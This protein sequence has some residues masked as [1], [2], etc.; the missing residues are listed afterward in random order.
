MLLF[1]V[2][3][4]PAGT[5]GWRRLLPEDAQLALADGT[6]AWLERARRGEL[7]ALVV[8]SGV[9]EPLSVAQRALAEDAD[10]AVVLISEPRGHE[11]LVRKLRF[12]PGLLGDVR[13]LPGDDPSEVA[14]V[15]ADAVTGTRKRRRYRQTLDAVNAQVKLGPR[16]PE[17]ALVTHLGR[18]LDVAPV[19]VCA[20]DEQGRILAW[21]HRAERIFERD[22]AQVMGQPF[23]A[24][25]PPEG[26]AEWEQLLAGAGTLRAPVRMELSRTE[27]PREVQHVELTSTPLQTEAGRTGLMVVMEDVTARVEAERDRAELLRQSQLALAV[28]DEFLQVASHELRT[29]LTSLR[30]VVQSV[31]RDLGADALT[32]EAVAALRQKLGTADRQVV[33]LTRLVEGLLDVSSVQSGR[34]R[35][36]RS[37]VDLCEVARLAVAELAPAFERAGC[38][39]RLQLRPPVKGAWDERR[40]FQVVTSLLSNAL[41]Y[42]PGTP[43]QIDVHAEE[44]VAVLEVRDRGIGIHPEDMARIFDRFERASPVRNYGGLGLGLFV[45]RKIVE[46]HEGTISAESG[47]GNGA[48]FRVE[49]PL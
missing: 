30:L 28:R 12:S 5:G 27:G 37:V 14:E 9:E 13:L 11:D 25:L 10:L 6:H 38:E 41:R 39:A 23:G 7:D 26:R 29:P 45:A 40:V 3:W 46:A 36:E 47:P 42:A 20:V 22:E 1:G 33:R 4:E 49:L 17:A 18:L 43:V 35:L 32:G 24:L 8:G 31:Q 34:L 2:E 15:L 16:P 19:G 21:N 48:R 44:G